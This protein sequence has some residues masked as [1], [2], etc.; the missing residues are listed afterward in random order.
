MRRLL[1]LLPFLL[2][3]VPE[4]SAQ[5]SAARSDTPDP[6]AVSAASLYDPAVYEAPIYYVVG[7]RALVYRNPDDAQAYL[8]LGFREPVYVLEESAA[9]RRVRTQDG[10]VGYVARDNVSN[11]WIRVS[12]RKKSL[13]LYQG[14][15][16]VMKVAAD[17]GY[18]PF[19]DKERRGSVANPD[20][21]R[22]PE[23]AFFVVR[24]NPRSKFYKAFVLNY[25]NAE[26]AARGLEQGLISRAQH[27]AIVAAERSFSM[28]PMS[29]PL[30]GMI[31]IH[32]DGTGASS[33]WTQGCVAVH[34]D[35]MD[36]LWEWVEV[37]T[38]VLVER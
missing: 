34:N 27:D 36:A 28:P 15:E 20:D 22:T 37:G 7:R 9:W 5:L 14:T 6:S 8:E 29:T 26:D 23:G 10:I 24:K 1:A 32:G 38:P 30:G 21:W 17:F 31:E 4:A 16:L 33:N 35:Q 18:N 12:K 19:A 3:L 25:P 13:Y 2:L 11:V